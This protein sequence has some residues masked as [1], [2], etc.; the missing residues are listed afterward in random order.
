MSQPLASVSTVKDVEQGLTRSLHCL[1]PALWLGSR[2]ETALYNVAQEAHLQPKLLVSS[3]LNG[4][5]AHWKQ[6]RKSPGPGPRLQVF[7]V[8][9]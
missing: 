1:L 7:I 6:Y 8:A 2:W 5:R 4:P 9:Y 3:F